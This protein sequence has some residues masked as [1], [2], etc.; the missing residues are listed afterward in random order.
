M[1][2]GLFFSILDVQ[3]FVLIDASH[4]SWKSMGFQLPGPGQA[5]GKGDFGEVCLILL[6]VERPKTLLNSETCDT[7]LLVSLKNVYWP[8]KT[9]WKVIS[10]NIYITQN[11]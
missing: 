10:Y 8:I 3:S 5:S 6:V 2:A 4:R 7:C 1:W 11:L 9:D